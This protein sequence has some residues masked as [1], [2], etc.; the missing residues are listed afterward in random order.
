MRLIT[1]IIITFLLSINSFS[2]YYGRNKIKYERFNF[3]LYQTPH[4]EIYTYIKDTNTI[5]TLSSISE[6]WYIRHSLIFKDTI[7]F[8]NPLIIYNNHADFQQ[9]TVINQIIDV[10][11]GGF[12]EA[13][14]NR[15]V[16]PLGISWARTDHVLGHELVHAFQ[17]FTILNDTSLSIRN[18]MNIPLW[19]VEGMAEYLSIGSY[20]AFTSMWIRDAIVNNKFPDFRKLETSH[21]FPYRWGQAFWAFIDGVYGPDVFVPLYKETARSGYAKAF[22]KVLGVKA[23]TLAKVWRKYNYE[24]YAKSLL[25]RQHEGIG[26]KLIDDKNGGD[27]NVN[28]VISP[29]G[30]YFIFLSEKDVYTFNMFLADA[31]TGKIIRRLSTRANDGHIDAAD[32][33][34]ST[35]TWSPDGKKIA[36]IVYEK[37]DN[38]LIIIDVY[39]G[40][41][42]RD[43]LLPKFK[44]FTYPSW[45]PDGKWIAF[46]VIENSQTDIVLYNLETEQIKRLTNDIFAQFQVSWSADGKYLAFVTDSF[47]G[48][49]SP[50]KKFHIA[51]INIETKEILVPKIMPNNNNLNPI[52]SVDNKF[53]YFLSDFKGFRDL[54][55]YNLKTGDIEK[56][57]NFKTGISGITMLSPAISIDYKNNRIFYTLYLDNKYFIYNVKIDSLKPQLLSISQA[58]DTFAIL[59]PIT[60]LKSIINKNIFMDQLIFSALKST[61]IA[62]KTMKKKFKVE[63]VSNTGFGITNTY[64]GMGV[65][66]G[67]NVLLGDILGENRAFIGFS[68]GGNG[69]QSIGGQIAYLNQE[70]RLWWGTSLSHTP[71]QTGYMFYETTRIPYRNDSL[72]VL[73]AGLDVLTIFNDNL[74]IFSSYPFT[75]TRR[76]E[77]GISLSLYS[78]QHQIINNYFYGNLFIGQTIENASKPQP[79]FFSTS[80]ISYIE[81]NSFMGMTSPL[82]GKIFAINLSSYFGSFYLFSANLDYRKYFRI[83]PITIAMRFLSSGRWGR[84]SEAGVFPDYNIVYP[85]LIRGYNYNTLVDYM[86]KSGT[87]QITYNF[88]GS[89]MAVFNLELR[90][91]FIGIERLALIQSKLLFADLN[92]FVDAGLAWYSYDKITLNPYQVYDNT[93]F[94][95]IS[96]GISAR[97]NLFG[98]LIVEPYVALPLSLSGYNGI[99]LGLNLM[100]GW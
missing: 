75:R 90:L 27:I 55:R 39:S 26:I 86:Q 20:D 83:Y 31:N 45:S 53:I 50:T 60:N 51:Y 78:F 21:Y 42:V 93:R 34:E 10:G 7:N 81:D 11:T 73:N 8:L 54:F 63:Y 36:F 92:A 37:G 4:F 88:F 98:Q 47:P 30:K 59:P 48:I 41:I 77:G 70:K 56:I 61:E 58:I 80:S 6:K 43:I 95:I 44:A 89:R 49:S 96:T 46:S 68:G 16:M 87:N 65:Y 15:I 85:W 99:S 71:Y 24:H 74:T 23:D 94:P 29:D 1:V 69:L 19:M 79:F 62:Q 76:L 52:F 5:K 3:K 91:P 14:E 72:D 57:T 22:K 9:N 33:Y 38:A 28:P 25:N 35:G 32:L 17:Y 97:I 12:T 84:D 100:S 40:K 82:E 18:V 64:H 2:Q 67:I 13:M 66:G